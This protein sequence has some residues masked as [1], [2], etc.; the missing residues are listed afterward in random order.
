MNNNEL[1]SWDCEVLAV[2]LF[3]ILKFCF[4]LTYSLEV[5]SA[6]THAP[7]SISV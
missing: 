2:D 7:T 3:S 5:L 1:M 6:V 4:I